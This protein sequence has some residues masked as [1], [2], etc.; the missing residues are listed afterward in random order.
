MPK[1]VARMAWRNFRTPAV[2]YPADPRAV[3]VLAACVVAGVPLVFA[4]AT[5]GTVEDKLHPAMVFVWGFLLVAGSA[6]TLVG[7]FKLNPDG[8]ILEQV[9]SVS[10]GAACMIYAGAMIATAGISAAVPA[11]IVGMFGV[12]CFW[13]W[14]QLQ[15]LL[16]RAEEAAIEARDGDE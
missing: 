15:G 5:P 3:F 12:A 6:T 9:G 1:R 2:R 8:I 11:L 4:G 14:G 13:R 7:T 10:V 16:H